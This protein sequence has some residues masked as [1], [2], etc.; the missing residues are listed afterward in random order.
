M[1]APSAAAQKRLSRAYGQ[2]HRR[3]L[4]DH[5][6]SECRR[7]GVTYVPQNASAIDT[8][9]GGAECRVSGDGGAVVTARLVTLAGGAVSAKFLEFEADAPPV[10][11]QT[12]YGIVARVSGYEDAYDPATMV[13]MD[14]RRAHSGMWDDTGFVLRR[15]SGRGEVSH[16]NWDPNQGTTGEP[17]S[18]LYAMPFR[19][20]TVFLEETCLVA[21]PVLPFAALKRRLCRR[22]AAM[23]IRIEEVRTTL[24]NLQSTMPNDGS[25]A[26]LCSQHP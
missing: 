4:R 26:Q 23:G 1:T 2:V 12:A 13:F 20:G 17:P 10:A 6:L 9:H 8:L 3:A 5:L 25:T 22:C 11:S 7:H 19:D 24:P 18:F 15:D 16:P 14:Y 21:R